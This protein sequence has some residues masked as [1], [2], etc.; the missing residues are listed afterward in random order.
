MT[1]RFLPGPDAYYYALQARFWAE[2]G[3]VKIPDTS[4]IHRLVG[5][6]HRMGM[7]VETAFWIWIV[8][9]VVIA[10]AVPVV[11]RLRSRNKISAWDFLLMI[12]LAISPTTLFIAIEFPKMMSMLMLV[13]LWFWAW[14]WGRK[15][16]FVSVGLAW[17]SAVLHK[18]ALALAFFWTAAG[19]LLFFL[20]H[21]VT[22]GT[23]IAGG[24]VFLHNWSPGIVSLLKQPGLPKVMRFELLLVG[25]LLMTVCLQFW[26]RNPIQRRMLLLP[27]S[28]LLSAFLPFPTTEVMNTAERLAILFPYLAWVGMLFLRSQSDSR[29]TNAIPSRRL[30][31]AI[32]CIVV[33]IMAWPYRLKFGHP[34]YL[35]PDYAAIAQVSNELERLDIPMLIAAKP[36]A[37]F[38]KYRTLREAF[39]FEPED[40]WNKSRIWR[41]VYKITP[42]EL[43]YYMPVTCNYGGTQVIPLKTP[44]YHL[45]REDCYAVMRGKITPQSDEDLY[46]RLWE[47]PMNPSQKRPRHLLPKHRDDSDSEFPAR[48]PDNV[49][50]R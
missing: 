11:L 4:P 47:T 29:R 23:Q 6:M 5:S 43:N 32:G 10:T 50:F 42:D 36:L 22:T 20:P 18:S 38:Y 49:T 45:V 3:G 34:Q 19:A 37:Y 27:I 31:I 8:L 1:P 30:Q 35:D 39:P 24:V 46:D 13:P 44:D 7:T 26:R 41:V 9:S 17:I 12:G 48:A 21:T 2:T 40:H 28:L 14:T 15:G 25:V 33:A 16:P